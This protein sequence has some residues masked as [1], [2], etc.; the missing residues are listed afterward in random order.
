MG[1]KLDMKTKTYTVQYSKR[2]PITRKPKT[3]RRKGIKTKAEA[4]R[5]YAELITQIHEVF[6]KTV[7]PC[8]QSVV[9]E[10]IDDFKLRDISMK[11]VETY[12]YCLKSHTFKLW[13]DR[14]V[15]SILSTEIRDVIESK[16]ETHS[17]S[18]RKNLLKYIRAALNYALEKGYIKSNP[19]PSMKFKIGNKIKN[20]LTEN[21][22]RTLLNQARV[23]GSQWYPI[24]AMACY[25]GMRNGELYALTWDRVNLD[26]RIIK[27][28]SSWNNKD[29]FKDTKSG[30]DRI[31]GIASSLLELLKELKLKG[32]DGP[33]VLPRI[34][35]WDK[36][37]Q[38]RELRMFLEGLGLPRIRFHDLRASWATIML[39]KGI[40]PIKVMAMG[41]WKDL[42]TM[43]YYVRKA[44]VDVSGIADC[45]DLHSNNNGVVLEFGSREGH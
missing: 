1:I 8:W 34:D 4:N 28:D 10:F 5:V 16:Q 30:D 3:L 45:L 15:D 42:K 20:V 38:A 13:E 26:D 39:S 7:I 23:I 32:Q 25:T 21:Q 12:N 40:P 35:R 31:V 43:Q 41:G 11:T 6:Q 18:H 9:N 33:F 36:G 19:T 44:G 2:H 22:I 14:L 24:W 29:G 17:T 27:V 37:D